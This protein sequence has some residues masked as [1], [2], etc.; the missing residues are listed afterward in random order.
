MYRTIKL[1][2]ILITEQLREPISILWTTIS[3]I[4]IFYYNLLNKSRNQ[5][6]TR[7]SYT[8]ISS[9]YFSYISASVAF[10][11][12]SL[13]IIGRRESGFIRS[14]IY[15]KQSRNTFLA[16]QILAYCTVSLIYFSTFYI[17]TSISITDYSIIH[18]A[19]LGA[20][21]ISCFFL[22]SIFGLL[23]TL[24][25]LSFQNSSTTMSIIIFT[26]VGSAIYSTHSN[27]HFLQYIN[28]INP[29]HYA[30]DIM[31]NGLSHNIMAVLFTAIFFPAT[32]L[33]ASKKMIINPV[34]SRY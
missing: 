23:I 9:L 13:Y 11:G 3:P 14:F 32:A 2:K 24:A 16:A 20:R 5:E 12:L 33:L 6:L 27:N 28:L 10:F 19:S 7:E 30:T 31:K 8:E 18:Y 21:F 1:V 25:P 17:I 26:A 4:S 29:V 15:T 22:F 34:W